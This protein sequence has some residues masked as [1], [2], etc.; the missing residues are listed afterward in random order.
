MFGN[1][2]I[3][4]QNL[5][6]SVAIVP[7]SENTF[8]LFWQWFGSL[9][10]QLWNLI[11]EGFY[12]VCK[13]LL[14]IVDF[15]Q[16]FIQKLIGLDYWLSNTKYTIEG[17]T[18]NDLLF[19]F[20]FD[21]T[22]QRVFRAMLG[23]FVALLIIFTIF[24]IIKQ[25]WTFI[26]GNN[27]GDGKGNSKGQI[28]R[29]SLKAIAMVLI[30]P[31]VLCAGIISSNAILASLVQALNI[32]MASTFGN[33]L[34]YI[35]SLSANKYR[36][37]ASDG[38]RDP[39]SDKV[40]FYV[41]TDSGDANEH[42]GDIGKVL[43]LGPNTNHSDSH[44]YMVSNYEDYLKTLK[45]CTHYSVNS[46]LDIVIPRKEREFNGYCIGI[47]VGDNKQ[48][49]MVKVQ[50]STGYH[51]TKEAWFY[52]LKH[53]LQVEIMSSTNDI[54]NG[55]IL[56]DIGGFQPVEGENCYIAGKNLTGIGNGELADA[57][58]NTYKYPQIMR[59]NGEFGNWQ[60]YMVLRN[61][62][63]RWGADNKSNLLTTIM[64]S[65]AITNAKILYNSNIAST[66]FDGGQQG[67][68][69]MNAEYN[70]MADVVDFMLENSLEL[71]MLNSTNGLID[72]NYKNMQNS[73]YNVDSRWTNSNYV[74]L[75][76]AK[77]DGVNS[78]STYKPFVV[79]YSEKCGDEFGNMLYLS[80]V[81]AKS[82]VD[83][84]VFIMC[85]KI[86]DNKFIPL[87]NGKTF[88]AA[89]GK[90]YR[91]KSSYYSS[92][93]AGAVIAKG[94]FTT[95]STNT[96]IG[97]P[98]YLRSNNEIY[99][100]LSSAPYYYE[101]KNNGR[102]VQ[103]AS[104]LGIKE[105]KRQVKSVQLEG[106][107]TISVVDTTPNA[108]KY[109]EGTLL[110][111]ITDAQGGNAIIDSQISNLRFILTDDSTA[112]SNPSL[113]EYTAEYTGDKVSVGTKDLYLFKTAGDEAY[114]YIEIDK[115]FNV[116]A[117]VSVAQVEIEGE[118]GEKVKTLSSTYVVEAQND[119]SETVYPV[120]LVN[121]EYSL[122][123]DY[124]YNDIKITNSD[125]RDTEGL[126]Y[127]FVA[128]D[129]KVSA[130]SGLQYDGYRNG[131]YLYASMDPIDI[132]VNITGTGENVKYETQTTRLRM[133]FDDDKLVKLNEKGIVFANA[134]LPSF[135][136][137]EASNAQQ[138]Y[139]YS[140]YL[141]NY[142][143]GAIVQDDGS[144]E[145]REIEWTDNGPALKTFGSDFNV[146]TPTDTNYI[147]NFKLN[148]GFVWD[149]DSSSIGVYD[150]NEYV[151]TLYKD[152]GTS[153]DLT[154]L[155][156]AT[157]S[158]LKDYQNYS[159]VLKENAYK[160]ATS[161]DSG[162]DG[163]SETLVGHYQTVSGALVTECLRDTETYAWGNYSELEYAGFFYFR[164]H[165]SFM[166]IQVSR[167]NVSKTFKITEGI[168][169]DYFFDGAFDLTDFYLPMKLNFI[170]M[171][172]S[173]VLII[174]ILGTALWGVIK[175]FYEITLYFLATP[176]VASTIPLDGGKRFTT[177][178][179]QPLIS[180][181]LSTYGIILGINVFFILLVPIKTMSQVFTAEDIATSNSYFL[182]ELGFSAEFLNLY[183]YVLFLLVAFTMINALP[184][185]ISEMLDANKNGGDVVESGKKT[186]GDVAKTVK[187][188]GDF[189][190]G[191]SAIDTTKKAWD[192]A[193]GA[194]PF[195][196]LVSAGRKKWKDHKEKKK[197]DEQ[198]G[199][200]AAQHYINGD[201]DKGKGKG[202]DAPEEAPKQSRAN[203]PDDTSNG[204]SGSGDFD[205]ASTGGSSRRGSTSPE[206]GGF[207]G[208]PA[209]SSDAEMGDAR[210]TDSSTMSSEPTFDYDVADDFAGVSEGDDDQIAENKRG[211]NLAKNV[212]EG[213]SDRNGMILNAA[214]QDS[215]I[216]AAAISQAMVE[217]G[218][219]EAFKQNNGLS[220]VA[221]DNDA[222]I[223]TIKRIITTSGGLDS[224]D[225]RGE[226]IRS[227]MK[228]P[229]FN[230][231]LAAA[232]RNAAENGTFNITAADLA[233]T[234]KNT[235]VKVAPGGERGASIIM[236]QQGGT[237]S[238][239]MLASMVNKTGGGEENRNAI[240]DMIAQ[241]YNLIDEEDE[242]K[243]IEELSKGGTV[244]TKTAEFHHDYLEAL[245]KRNREKIISGEWKKQDIL[246]DL[247]TGSD[248][249]MKSAEAL[250]KT[251]NGGK[252]LQYASE[253]ERRE[254]LITN[255]GDKFKDK[256]D[257]EFKELV[258]SG[259]IQIASGKGGDELATILSTG[260]DL[261][262]ILGDLSAS[263][264]G[265]KV[266]NSLKENFIA[267]KMQKDITVAKDTSSMSASQRAEYNYNLQ[268]LQQQSRVKGNSIIENLFN[269]TSLVNKDEIQAE[270]D[271]I[272]NDLLKKNRGLRNNQGLARTQ[273]M[274]LY[275]NKHQDIRE[276]LLKIGASDITLALSQK[277]RSEL[278]M[279]AKRE[280]PA[281]QGVDPDSDP[282]LRT[283]LNQEMTKYVSFGSN[284]SEADITQF[285][286][287]D[288]KK[289]SFFKG[290]LS[291][292]FADYRDI[293]QESGDTFGAVKKITKDGEVVRFK[294]SKLRR[295]VNS[296]D[297]S[298]RVL[299]KAV[300]SGD[301]NAQAIMRNNLIGAKTNV[302]KFMDLCKQ[303]FTDGQDFYDK[304]TSQFGNN[305]QLLKKVE[306]MYKKKELFDWDE[307]NRD[308]V[309]ETS[310]SPAIQQRAIMSLLQSEL[311]QQ[312]KRVRSN[313]AYI[314]SDPD[315]AATF[316]GRKFGKVRKNVNASFDKVKAEKLSNALAYARDNGS[317]G[318]AKI[319]EFIAGI[320]PTLL[321]GLGKNATVADIKN[322]LDKQLL[323]VTTKI[324]KDDTYKAASDV[325]KKLGGVRVDKN[326]LFRSGMSTSAMRKMDP[327]TRG[328]YAD[329]TK[330]AKALAASHN[331]ELALNQHL[332]EEYKKYG[333]NSTEAKRIWQKILESNDKLKKLSPE[334]ESA[335]KKKAEYESKYA[336]K[337]IQAAK[338][339]GSGSRVSVSSGSKVTGRYEF[340]TRDGVKVPA[341]SDLD[342]RIEEISRRFV[343]Q[344]KANLER[345]IKSLNDK[346]V[347]DLRSK[348]NATSSKL[349]SDFGSNIN[350][351]KA[352][353]ADIQKTIRKLNASSAKGDK[354]LT[355]ELKDSANR[356]KKVQ[357]ELIASLKQL[358]IEISDIKL[359]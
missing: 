42:L 143:T 32:D 269:N 238:N 329:I 110:Y 272:V 28:L 178:I 284:A 183:V 38:Y 314:S 78:M 19:G 103:Y 308:I 81:N 164:F 59:K 323:K 256:A 207:E 206:N 257:R 46:M 300:R 231:H 15:L 165:I 16:Y 75:P 319:R 151:A 113:I 149:E 34:F 286:A 303:R 51:N 102:L 41:I 210:A 141:Y 310:K 355:Q 189:I 337:Q 33:T 260:I 36:K 133:F 347:S 275:M 354:K 66:Y 67:F 192:T 1:L 285:F 85:I 282:K 338:V 138:S 25:E 290:K 148:S 142:N 246:L 255:Y 359:K 146:P 118:G 153:I 104:N 278:E 249:T 27:F 325:L 163:S 117:P 160:Y 234:V 139:M 106:D 199:N 243:V 156:S 21:E 83:G 54:G 274:N 233:R 248:R 48:Y 47:N 320:D 315:V 227:A 55:P 219:M 31:I 277:K 43:M 306:A 203:E 53:I 241:R 68:V 94:T 24:A 297:Y 157:T 179:Q 226:S 253:N 44:I 326:D 239:K 349:S 79:S 305:P 250:Y 111:R 162:Y 292:A 166:E 176:A 93:Y 158:I 217:S 346:T 222:V 212:N 20:L 201:E 98:T 147:I 121:K 177:A 187:S 209:T 208:A 279:R 12:V 91:F 97:R 134:V 336:A 122:M 137:L 50:N 353:Q 263:D 65:S 182:K 108:E 254:F 77:N 334:L 155:T 264:E 211:A 198:A 341:G 26:T 228:D 266:I 229:S 316:V 72:W 8:V 40:N 273:A 245:E 312:T 184:K 220:G 240:M 221:N 247:I 135:N 174:K 127:Q 7:E 45:C 237:I 242:R 196:S 129:N 194:I 95:N 115:E 327:E 74:K 333:F 87:V 11:C 120:S 169:F 293:S 352:T 301:E 100:E 213:A 267:G 10:V 107:S 92:G 130:S 339:S 172:F 136:G 335:L 144:Y 197:A 185:T 350:A 181:V 204:G 188:T 291:D 270:I 302:D 215:D 225:A 35:S 116:I 313:A 186:K 70:V 342:R 236:S 56:N 99:D 324:Q 195:S 298:N 288:R 14:A 18:S 296:G 356:T 57:C 88:K 69:A 180:K 345:L 317:L 304:F 29:G 89:D 90:T 61:G 328:A 150:G 13:W 281:L 168:K 125:S 190:S 76:D 167:E 114:F 191:K 299:K 235:G 330:V 2:L 309:G 84:A 30:F 52:Y 223:D 202:K 205:D 159:N 3:T 37:Y 344:N 126:G 265:K 62:D 39:V 73:D 49:Y 271:E 128:E 331:A 289:T 280:N 259:K 119:K 283:L 175:R 200:D 193:K 123:Y 112:S 294:D 295:R 173:S 4:F 224:T 287:K 124:V 348:I 22:I 258:D 96:Q 230:K 268:M 232:T 82:E 322:L 244:S 140:L 5:F 357:E 145:L 105:T 154:N 101:M 6:S 307:K 351:L 17:A 276:E 218:S 131:Y 262:K 132:T 152:R 170:I 71:Y 318:S 340:R 358:G 332:K 23:I 161:N 251:E 58:Y 63:M 9:F 214:R 60:N 64:G 171:I 261:E 109:A 80:D 252:E 343:M 216:M 86:S 321:K 311:K